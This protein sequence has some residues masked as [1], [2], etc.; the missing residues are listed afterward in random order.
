ML[1]Y[2]SPFQYGKFYNGM[3][4]KTEKNRSPVR[5]K[6]RIMFLVLTAVLSAAALNPSYV[7]AQTT[8]AFVQYEI[9]IE[10]YAGPEVFKSDMKKIVR[11]AV[12]SGAECVVFPEYTNVFLATFPFAEELAAVLSMEEGLLLIQSRFGKES[13]LRDFFL[14]QAPEVRKIM[15]NVWGG[16]AAEYNVWI[17]AGTAFASGNTDTGGLYN[18]LYIYNPAGKL[19][20]TQDKVYLTPFESGVIGLDSGNLKDSRTIEIG[21]IECGFTICRDTF[22]DEWEQLFGQVDVWIDVKANGAEFN[23]QTEELFRRALP[24]RISQSD[25]AGGA[26]VCLTGSFLELF[27]EGRSSIILKDFGQEGYKVVREAR[28]ALG[29]EILFWTFGGE[30]D[31]QP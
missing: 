26:T 12:Q 29:Q 6:Y 7:S 8:F 22:F 5:M 24:E 28:S 3:K 1:L 27:W 2:T 4:G 11:S 30:A 31:L 10:T 16:L 25:A 18:R 23:R 9:D 15:D 13:D 21:D 17:A 19:S 20:Y 14:L